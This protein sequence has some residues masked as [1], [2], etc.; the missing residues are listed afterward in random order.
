MPITQSMLGD[1]LRANTQ[2]GAEMG[3]A[4]TEA[5]LRKYLQQNEPKIAAETETAQTNADISALEDPRVQDFIKKGGSVAAGKMHFGVDPVTHNQQNIMRG[6][7]QAISQAQHQYNQGIPKIQSSLSAASEGLDAINDPNNKMSKGQLMGAATRALGLSRFPNKEEAKMLLPPTLQAQAAQF[8]NWLGDDN[9]PLNES[10]RK[11]GGSFLKSII[12]SQEQQHST[13][14]QNAINTAM[15]SPYSSG[16][17]TIHLSTMGKPMEDMFSKV[18]SRYSKIPETAGPNLTA[19]PNPGIMGKLQSFFAPKQQ[20]QA[21]QQ[22]P[23][24]PQPP[25]YDFDAEDKR[26][27]TAKIQQNAQPQPPQQGQGQ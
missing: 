1:L 21:P 13:L 5:S 3:K 24:P 27:A 26:R 16:S 15:S 10:D 14:K 4:G 12:D 2:A 8:A 7:G 23:S 9:N 22:P 20:Q 18:K 17:T 25:M 19:T 11:A 6:E